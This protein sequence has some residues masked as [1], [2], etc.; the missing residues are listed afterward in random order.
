MR[1]DQPIERRVWE[2]LDEGVGHRFSQESG[3]LLHILDRCLQDELVMQPQTIPPST[4]ASN[5]RA[6][7]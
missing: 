4:P 5:S 7:A 3:R 6:S 1:L 2:Q